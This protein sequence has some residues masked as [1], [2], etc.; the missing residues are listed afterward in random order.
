MACIEVSTQAEFD[1]AARKGDCVHVKAG[2]FTASGSASVRAYGSASVT[3]YGSASVT[4]SK[5]VAGHVN[6]NAKVTGGVQIIVPSTTS[7][8]AWCERYGVHIPKA[9]NPV[10]TLFKVVDKDFRSPHGFDYTP[11]TTPVAPDWDGGV[12]E[13]GYG[14]HFSPAPFMAE[15]FADSDWWPHNLRY[16]ACPVRLAVIA[17]HA[18][19]S[20]P[21]KV[22]AKGCC[23]PVYEVDVDGKAVAP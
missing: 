15:R 18:D 21:D 10:V 17:V 22:K 2:A 16:V 14:L 4:A 23:K 3:A 12:T 1:A 19:A 5:C 9:K 8:V 6:Q 7:A 11:G 20:Y 13:C